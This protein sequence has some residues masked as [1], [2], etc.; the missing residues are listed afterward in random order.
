MNRNFIEEFRKRMM[1]IDHP[2]EDI[3][4]ARYEE[5]ETLIEPLFSIYKR[6]IPF[7]RHPLNR[8]IATGMPRK[9]A[10]EMT[11]KLIRKEAKRREEE[12]TN[13]FFMYEVVRTGATTDERSP[14]YNEGS[15]VL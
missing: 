9:E 1:A 14:F 8:M 5:A 6:A 2:I 11:I 13:V 3:P 10:D 15:P 12:N 4:K 7:T